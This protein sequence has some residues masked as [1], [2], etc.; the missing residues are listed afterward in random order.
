MRFAFFSIFCIDAII[1]LAKTSM[2]DIILFL[3]LLRWSGGLE[4][5]YQRY[6]KHNDTGI[7]GFMALCEKSCSRSFLKNFAWINARENNNLYHCAILQLTKYWDLINENEKK[8]FI[9]PFYRSLFFILI[10]KFHRKNN[11]FTC[12]CISFKNVKFLNFWTN[13]NVGML[14]ENASWSIF[15]NFRH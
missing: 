13:F 2:A 10:Y 6:N 5:D 11:E 1:L 3:F 14:A 15:R 4:K 9:F 7:I 12:T 8:K